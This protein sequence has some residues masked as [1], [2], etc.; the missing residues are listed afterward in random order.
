M[1]KQTAEYRRPSRHITILKPRLTYRAIRGRMMR[2]LQNDRGNC[3]RINRFCRPLTIPPAYSP[4]P[5]R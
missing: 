4:S 3:E 2:F 1:N 5:T